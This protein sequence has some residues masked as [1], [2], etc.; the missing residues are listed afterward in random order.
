MNTATNNAKLLGIDSDTSI[1]ECCG[2]KNLKKVAVIEL[3][4]GRVVRYGRNCAAK[5][6]GKSMITSIDFLAEI[7]AYTV[8]RPY[9]YSID[10]V[11][12]ALLNKF[13]VSA[14]FVDGQF[15]IHGVGVI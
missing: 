7:S 9:F 13:G 12:K 1:C 6:L 5:K 2:K 14:K 11:I 10:S 15:H 8:S 3:A 4:D